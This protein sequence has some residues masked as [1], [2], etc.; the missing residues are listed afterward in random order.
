MTPVGFHHLVE[1]HLV[2]RVLVGREPVLREQEIPTMPPVAD[3]HLFPGAVLLSAAT[4]KPMDENRSLHPRAAWFSR[5]ATGINARRSRC[6]TPPRRRRPR[7]PRRRRPAPVVPRG[8]RQ[9]RSRAQ[10]RREK[11]GAAPEVREARE[12]G[13]PGSRGVVVGRGLQREGGG[14]E[15]VDADA[16]SLR[17]MWAGTFSRVW[18]AA[19]GL[20]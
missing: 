2:P 9:Q 4:D 12:G 3:V 1:R 14:E 8:A 20:G 10:G 19:R 13:A 18:K 7:N 5:S 6:A 15:A 16:G 11:R 17:V